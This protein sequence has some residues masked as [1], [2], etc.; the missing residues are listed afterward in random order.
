MSFWLPKTTS[1]SKLHINGFSCVLDL[2]TAMIDYY[3]L[4]K[5][6]M[7]FSGTH[8]KSAEMC[9]SQSQVPAPANRVAFVRWCAEPNWKDYKEIDRAHVNNRM[10]ELRV[11]T[12]KMLNVR[13]LISMENDLKYHSNVFGIAWIGDAV[14]SNALLFPSRCWFDRLPT[15]VIY[16]WLKH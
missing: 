6:E 7:Q 10:C 15:H 16:I 8:I 5:M 3:R 2:F 14:T 11:N 13:T 12:I 4:I 9:K 1:N